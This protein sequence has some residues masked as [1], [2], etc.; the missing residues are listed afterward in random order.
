MSEAIVG[1][2]LPAPLRLAVPLTLSWL[3]CTSTVVPAMSIFSP[4]T[5]E[6]VAAVASIP[7]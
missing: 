4:P 6:T 7:E 5:M 2:A 1:R 3:N